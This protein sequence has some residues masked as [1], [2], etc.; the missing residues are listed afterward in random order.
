[1]Y[2]SAAATG[3]VTT[4]AT[5]VDCVVDGVVDLE[6][7][8][9]CDPSQLAGSQLAGDQPFQDVQAAPSSPPFLFNRPAYCDASSTGLL[10]RFVSE[11]YAAA[12]ECVVNGVV[13]LVSDLPCDLSQL[14]GAWLSDQSFQ[15]APPSPP[16]L[17]NRPATCG[18]SSTPLLSRFVSEWYAAAVDCVADG[19]VDLV[20][21]L[22]CDLSQLVGAWL[23]DQSFQNAPSSPPFLCNRP[24]KCGASSTPLLSR[25]V[26]EW[27]AAAVDCVADGVVDL[28]SDLPCDLSQLVGAWLS[29][30]SFQDA[31]PSPPFLCNRPANCDA[32]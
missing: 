3:P 24:A 14:V 9:P 32:S 8:Q 1:M 18:A 20:S 22:P 26:S 27:Y 16:F 4:V 28:V 25:F 10:S 7:D 5:V 15:D 11:W 12:V 21:D 6:A 17:C 30:Q 31:P 23:S 29:D 13:D 19:V 2:V